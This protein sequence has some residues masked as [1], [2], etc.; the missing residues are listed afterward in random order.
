MM[1]VMRMPANVRMMMCIAHDETIIAPCAEGQFCTPG[2][3][4]LSMNGRSFKPHVGVDIC[5]DCACRLGRVI[6]LRPYFFKDGAIII[7]G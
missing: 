3:G 4:S 6:P 7:V 1:V 2:L 5:G